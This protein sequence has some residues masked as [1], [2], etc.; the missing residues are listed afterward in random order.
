MVQAATD[1]L[2]PVF[3]LLPVRFHWRF[4]SAR[5]AEHFGVVSAPGKDR[6]APAEEAGKMKFRAIGGGA[7][8]SVGWRHGFR[9]AGFL[10]G[11]RHDDG[12]WNFL[13]GSSTPKVCQMVFPR[14]SGEGCSSLALA[15]KKKIDLQG[16]GEPA[17]LA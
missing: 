17:R 16:G 1:I 7:V 15:L 11:C 3:D 4:L 8:R 2:L 5:R 13:D 9:V 12:I 14:G 10:W 6:F